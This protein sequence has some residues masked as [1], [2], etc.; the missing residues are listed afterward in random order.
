MM[1]ISQHCMT[2]SPQQNSAE[3]Q[4]FTQSRSVQPQEN[5]KESERKVKV[6]PYLI[7]TRMSPAPH[8]DSVSVTLGIMRDIV[9][10]VARRGVKVSDHLAG[11][12]LKSVYQNPDNG[13]SSD[14]PLDRDDI[15]RLVGTCTERLLH[16]HK[17]LLE[18]IRM[19]AA[20]LAHY[21]TGEDVISDHRHQLDT[22]LASLTRMV[23]EDNARTKQGLDSL[24]RRMV[25]LVVLRSGL[26]NPT[27]PSVVAEAN[28]CLATVFP[29][30]PSLTHHWSVLSRRALILISEK[31]IEL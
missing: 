27:D 17:P 21:G 31:D 7:E 11:C 19:Q 18:T 23:V 6:E 24:Y 22:K 26:G 8:D 15:R 1:K 14:R 5:K 29:V 2:P 12:L 13:F 25:T 16:D 10:E 3:D 20:W 9:T 28:T 4:Q 30:S